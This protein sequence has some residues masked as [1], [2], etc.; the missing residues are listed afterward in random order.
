[1]PVP[2]FQSLM[3]SV[4]RAAADGEIAAKDLRDRVASEV[5]LSE[6][7]LAEMLPSGRQTTF[8]NRTAWANVFLQR[9]GLLERVGRGVYRIT[10]KGRQALEERPERIDMRLLERYPSYVEWRQRS[11]S[12]GAIAG[13]AANE[14][15]PAIFNAADGTW[16][17]RAASRNGSAR[18]WN[19]QFPMRRYAA[20]RCVFWRGPSRPRM[21]SVATP[22][23]YARPS[24]GFGS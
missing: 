19:C 16:N 9:A 13:G 18:R 15:P 23:T 8:V 20:R 14:E 24:A 10:D 11:A 5:G 1:M 3:L 6:S 12:G 7:D 4:L 21:R 2:D 17:Q 22:G